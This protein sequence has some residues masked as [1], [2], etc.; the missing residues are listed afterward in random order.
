MDHAEQQRQVALMED[1]LPLLERWRDEAQDE[2]ERA[3]RGE[4][5]AAYR[6]NLREIRALI[7]SSGAMRSRIARLQE[8]LPHA[9]ATMGEVFERRGGRW[10]PKG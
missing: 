9:G 5:V 8:H 2:D 4:L 1:E 10:V 6:A 3:E 7:R